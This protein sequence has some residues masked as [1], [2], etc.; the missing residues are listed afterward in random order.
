MP[1]LFLVRL[2]VKEKD[3][4]AAAPDRRSRRVG[5]LQPDGITTAHS[6]TPQ[7]RGVDANVSPIV[8]GCPAQDT[9]ILR[10]IALR[11]GRHHAAGART[12]DAQAEPHSRSRAFSLSRVLYE[13]VLGL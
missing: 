6:A 2:S 12:S 3:F 7:H 5:L 11:E 10:Q 8:L 9:R 13:I 4:P 1:A